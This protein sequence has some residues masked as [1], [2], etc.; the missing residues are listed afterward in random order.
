MTKQGLLLPAWEISSLYVAELT[1]QQDGLEQRPERLGKERAADRMEGER[2]GGRGKRQEMG[3]RERPGGR[4]RRQVRLSTLQL[5]YN[6][7]GGGYGPHLQ[8]RKLR[9]RG[10]CDLPKSPR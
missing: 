3:E 6:P 9:L 5:I 8:K 2:D 10:L 7:G 4:G 1:P